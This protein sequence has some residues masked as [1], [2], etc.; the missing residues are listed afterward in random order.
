MRRHTLS[1]PLRSGGIACA[2]RLPCRHASI[3]NPVGSAL[4][5][6]LH[7]GVRP[8]T[9]AAIFWSVSHWRGPS[10]TTQ[11]PG[12]GTIGS[13]TPN[14]LYDPP[15]GVPSFATEMLY[16]PSSVLR[17]ALRG[18]GLC[19]ARVVER[20]VNLTRNPEAVQQHG[21]LPRH[22]HHGPLL[23]VLAAAHG[24]LLAVSTEVGVFA[25]RAQHVVGATHQEPP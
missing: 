18:P 3:R 9:G 8:R 1:R 11:S 24:E 16:L 10:P 25:E 5:G 7:D 2:S 17:Q 13:R 23:G 20:F 14:P 4:A 22:G 19:L 6:R 12:P 15:A 21:E